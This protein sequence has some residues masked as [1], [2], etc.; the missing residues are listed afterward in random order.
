MDEEEGPRP[1]PKVALL[2]D[3]KSREVQARG[4]NRTTRPDRDGAQTQ[5][6]TPRALK[7]SAPFGGGFGE[8]APKPP[9][10]PREASVQG[11]PR[12]K[13]AKKP[14]MERFWAITLYNIGQRETSSAGLRKLLSGRVLRHA[15][16]LSGEERAAA[17]AEGK[18]LVEAT[19]ARA[20]KE[21]L[22]D[23]GRFAEMKARSWRNKGW[24]ER[25]IAMEMRRQ[26]MDSDVAQ[27]ALGQVDA[28]AVDGVDDPDVLAREADLLA[29]DTLCQRRKIGPYRKSQ[30][31]DRDDQIRVFR[32]EMGVLARAGFSGDLIKT[33]LGRPPV[34]EDID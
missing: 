14:N 21:R 18:D 13:V 2:S 26:G 34:D 4:S 22:I 9:R 15:M 6:P 19:V 33:M 5:P 32:R 7:A 31:V 29:A 28:D 23:D 3:L 1:L 20:L 11:G 10:K 8:G 24:G 27:D 16:G 12:R 25:R 17:E 30:P